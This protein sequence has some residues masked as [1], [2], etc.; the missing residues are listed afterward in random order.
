MG[1][2]R[3]EWYPTLLGTELIETYAAH[4]H[5]AQAFIDS[6]WTSVQIHKP[7]Y[8]TLAGELGGAW[9]L[10]VSLVA[11]AYYSAT[12]AKDGAVSMVTDMLSS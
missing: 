1:G 11:I 12:K 7:G 9:T 3:A 10:C 6:Q 4:D 5:A 8:L 2:A